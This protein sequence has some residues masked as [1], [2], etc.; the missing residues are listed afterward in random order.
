M[1]KLCHFHPWTAE[2]FGRM[3]FNLIWSFSIVPVHTSTSQRGAFCFKCKR[4]EAG[5]IRAVSSAQEAALD[6]EMT[7]SKLLCF[8]YNMLTVLHLS[9]QISNSREEVWRQQTGQQKKA[10]VKV[11]LDRAV[12]QLEMAQHQIVLTHVNEKSPFKKWCRSVHHLEALLKCCL[13]IRRHWLYQLWSVTAGWHTDTL[14]Y[15]N[16]YFFNKV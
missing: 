10:C 1:S 7:L 6:A 14:M 9:V 15:T 4:G 13:D 12:G 3:Q 11:A 5:E 2:M 8:L 16:I